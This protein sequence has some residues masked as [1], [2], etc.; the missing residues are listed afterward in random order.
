MIGFYFRE[1]NV[2]SKDASEKLKKLFAAEGVA[3]RDVD[4]FTP[5]AE[6]SQLS[7]LVVFGGDG[8]V[9]QA[10]KIA[11][12]DIPIVAIN[13]GNVGFL[14]SYEESELH[15]LVGDYKRGAL[16]FSKRR[17]LKITCGKNEYYALNDVAVLKNYQAD[18]ASECVKLKFYI[19]GQFVDAFVADGLVVST[20]TGSTA[21]AL[22]AGGPI[23]P[24]NVKAL[25]CAPICAH[26]LHSRPIVFAEDS[27]AVVKVDKTSKECSLF[28]DGAI[29]C[30]VPSGESFNVECSD[31]SV[32]ICE[33][34]QNFFKKLLTKLNKW[35]SVELAVS[36]EEIF[37]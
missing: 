23:M 8:S 12:S 29:A 3:Y 27:T 26:S 30:R 32:S 11:L 16:N 34:K 20:P 28:I 1:G 18:S 25:V 6:R 10:A 19:D 2:K 17:L 15:N 37:K 13:T 5:A 7:L 9:L 31:Q 22:S 24:P 14:T 35:T 33:T 4:E 36:K 21:Y